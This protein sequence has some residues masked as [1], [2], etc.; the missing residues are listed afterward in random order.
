MSAWPCPV[1]AA[2]GSRPGSPSGVAGRHPHYEPQGIG[3]REKEGARK[4]AERH[5]VFQRADVDVEAA[6]GLPTGGQSSRT[7]SGSYL[8]FTL[9]YRDVALGL[10]IVSE[11]PLPSV[12]S[13]L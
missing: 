12:S 8:R 2:I 13:S 9:S 10:E 5:I 7:R 3:P 1:I 6:G 11:N 4:A